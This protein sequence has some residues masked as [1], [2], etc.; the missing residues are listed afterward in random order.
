MRRLRLSTVRLAVAVAV[1]AAAIAVA[2][3]IALA[4]RAATPVGTGVVVV[5]TNLAYQNSSASGSGIVL[6]SKGEILT[7]NHVIRGAT[8]IRVVIPAANRTYTA[9]VL[10]YSISSDVALLELRGASNLKT[11]TLGNSSTLRAGSSVTAVGNAGGTGAIVSSTG[12]ITGL[13]RAI[14]VSDDAGGTEHLT[15]LIETDAGLQPGDSGGPL[16]NASGQV[17]GMDTAA[18]ARVVFTGGASEGY[19]IPI[20]RALTIVHQIEAGHASTTVHLGGTAFLGVELA[21]AAGYPGS[22]SGGM[23]VGVVPGSPAAT[24]GISDGAVI[25]SFAGHSVTTPQSLSPLVLAQKPGA[26][27]RI[28][29]TDSFGTSHSATVTLATGPAQ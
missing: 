12:S 18:S 3:G 15:G 27:V 25:T 10:G 7:N 24:A 4:A 1:L 17:I 26:K 5:K 11:A 23:V 2:A 19:A 8:T 16:V 21:S 6:T 29:W 13:S 9:T 22:P 14:D 28:V 20:N